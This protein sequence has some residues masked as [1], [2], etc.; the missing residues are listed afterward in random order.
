MQIHYTL[1]WGGWHGIVNSRNPPEVKGRW[2]VLCG[3]QVDLK[4]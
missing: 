3:N 1:G 2:Q 4:M